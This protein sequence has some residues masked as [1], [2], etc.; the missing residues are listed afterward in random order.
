MY[1]TLL[2]SGPGRYIGEFYGSSKEIL[3]ADSAYS[4]QQSLLETLC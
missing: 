4:V 3:T 2:T 1:F